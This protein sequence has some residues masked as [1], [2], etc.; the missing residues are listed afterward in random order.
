MIWAIIGLVM[1][2]AISA[3]IL[4]SACKLVRVDPP[5]FFPAMVICFLNM[6]IS[7]AAPV[8]IGVI[9]VFTSGKG[10]LG[11]QLELQVLLPPA[12]PVA[13]VLSPFISAGV[14][15]VTLAQGNY[16]KGVQIWLAQ[17][18]VILVFVLV[19][20]GLIYALDLHKKL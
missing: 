17:F 6:A 20:G 14:Y 11:P 10:D 1:G 19:F 13:L 5:E 3:V 9:M 16:W 8:I 15:G 12:A 4:S 18:L 7:F 2:L